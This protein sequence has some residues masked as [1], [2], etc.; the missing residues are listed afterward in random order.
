M[1]NNNTNLKEVYNKI[2][3]DWYKDHQQDDWWVGGTDTFISFLKPAALV[4]DVGCGAGIKS[5][6]FIRKG[7][8]VIGID[9]SEKMIEI[10]NREVS[11][12]TFLVCDLGEVNTLNYQF[13]GIF[14]QAVL[15]HVSKAE[16][17]DKLAVLTEKLNQG[18]YL[19]IAVKE[20]KIG[21]ADEEIKVENDY[22]Y[23][24]SRFFSYYTIEEIESYMGKLG[25]EI[26]YSDIKH[27]GKTN[28][29]QVIAKK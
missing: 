1:E 22:G 16:A 23:S 25:L 13:D 12:G 11:G 21:E 17:M 29:I 18:G 14:L 19:Y 2:A 8:R 15:L 9:F 6:Y 10:A 20:K 5:N 24:Y 3:E 4:L 28:W 7:I 26:L 27:S